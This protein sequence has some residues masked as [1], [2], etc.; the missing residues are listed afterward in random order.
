MLSSERGH[1]PSVK[2]SQDIKLVVVSGSSVIVI[3]GSSVV[4]V[5]VDP[6]VV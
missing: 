5:G 6:G 1:R 4:L 2:S 3:V